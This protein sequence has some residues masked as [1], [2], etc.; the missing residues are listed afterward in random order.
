MPSFAAGEKIA[1]RT[2]SNKSLVAAAK[3]W[4]NLVG[5]SADLQGPNAVA[6]PEAGVYSA[7]TRAGRYLHFGIRF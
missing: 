7:A 3:A 5:G 6:M 1:T 4:T 2:A